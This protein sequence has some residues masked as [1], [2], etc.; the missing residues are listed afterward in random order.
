MSSWARST[1]ILYLAPPSIYSIATLLT[2]AATQCITG[3]SVHEPTQLSLSSSVN[4]IGA[5]I[6]DTSISPMTGNPRK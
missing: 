2:L 1:W 3:I 4:F 5:V 6:Y